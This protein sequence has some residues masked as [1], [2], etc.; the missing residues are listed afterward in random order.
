MDKKFISWL[1][2]LI[3]VVG[4]PL[5]MYAGIELMYR[6]EIK[7]EHYDTVELARAD[8]LFDRGWMTD[9]FPKD[10]GPLDV[11][12]DIDSNAVCAKAI[13]RHEDYKIVKQSIE[14]NN[15]LALRTLPDEHRVVA[16]FCPFRAEATVLNT[17]LFSMIKNGR[18]T[19]FALGENGT[20]YYWTDGLVD[21]EGYQPPPK[22]EHVYEAGIRKIEMSEIS[23]STATSGVIHLITK[24]P[25]NRYICKDR[26]AWLNL[27]TGDEWIEE[28]H[29]LDSGHCRYVTNIINGETY[30]PFV[31][32][33]LL[34][35][36]GERSAKWIRRECGELG[37]VYDDHLDPSPY[38]HIIYLLT[39][40]PN[41][42]SS[43]GSFIL[44]GITSYEGRE[45]YALRSQEEWGSFFVTYFD[46]GTLLPVHEFHYHTDSD[47]VDETSFVSETVPVESLP[48]D[49]FSQ[50]I[51]EGYTL[52]DACSF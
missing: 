49:H 32:L 42:Y 50:V 3:L 11:A 25:W 15:Y 43:A 7:T 2:L 41:S 39:R 21:R 12:Y 52:Y 47:T 5:L 20:L 13:V 48:P 14:S 35:S 23:T 9:V 10:A 28:G 30:S 8:G 38:A 36:P 17:D 4:V 51:P 45:V 44:D 24:T 19:Y 22:I 29:L 34:E 46:R 33:A 40:K 31:N 18:S 26:E 6:G 27:D 37:L 1:G 16:N